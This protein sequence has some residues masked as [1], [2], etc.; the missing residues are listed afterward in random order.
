M[1]TPLPEEGPSEAL[2]FEQIPDPLIGP[3]VAKVT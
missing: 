2:N 3:K 1:G